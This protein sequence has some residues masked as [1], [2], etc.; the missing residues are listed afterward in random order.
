MDL[1]F[2]SSQKSC[3][4]PSL[5]TALGKVTVVPHNIGGALCG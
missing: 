2:S 4:L 3:V 1:L 5:F